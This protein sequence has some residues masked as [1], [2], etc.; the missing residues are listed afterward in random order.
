M[1]TDKNGQKWKKEHQSEILSHIKGIK[2][3]QQQLRKCR[4][5]KKDVEKEEN[6]QQMKYT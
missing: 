1:E 2:I 6:K 4:Q 5:I 3:H